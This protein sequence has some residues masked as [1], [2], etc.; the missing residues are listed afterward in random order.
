[1][2][3]AVSRNRTNSS[4][5]CGHKYRAGMQRASSSVCRG[6]VVAICPFALTIMS[7]SV[8]IH[9]LDILRTL[10]SLRARSERPGWGTLGEDNFET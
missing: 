2:S 4:V 5:G 10:K 3:A 9:S 1:M 8:Q 7:L 6:R